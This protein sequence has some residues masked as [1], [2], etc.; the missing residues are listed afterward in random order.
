MLPIRRNLSFKLP[1]GRMLDWNPRGAHVTTFFNTLSIFFPSGERFFI[2]AVRYYRDKGRITD[3]ELLKAVTAFIGQEAM[4]GR[5]HEEYNEAVAEAGLPVERMEQVVINLLEVLKRRLPPSMRLG[6]TVALEHFT[7]I[8]ADILLR[9]PALLEG[10]EPHFAALWQWHALEETEHK[11]V[12][13]DVFQQCVGTG[14]KGYAVRVASLVIATVLFWSLVIPFHIELMR[15][16]GKLFDGR[17]WWE[18]MKFQW[19]KPGGLRR[20]IPAYFEYYKPGFHPWDQ[21][22]RAFLAR[23]QAIEDEYRAAA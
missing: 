22:N 18:L 11:A 1:K 7:A 17:G 9:E 12:A 3:P 19:L 2:D 13:Y 16:Q 14:V 20:I 8:L 10:A 6:A 23:I 4:H 15:R 21:D 5:E